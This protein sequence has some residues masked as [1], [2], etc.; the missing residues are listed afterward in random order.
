MRTDGEK[1]FRAIL[2]EWSKAYPTDIF[3]EP[4]PGEHGKT[5]AACSAAMGRHV[6]R[7]LI[8][9]FDRLIPEVS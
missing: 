5:V 2:E 3:I 7:V 1:A 4:P 8:E 9:D 6:I